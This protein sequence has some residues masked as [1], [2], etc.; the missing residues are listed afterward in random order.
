MLNSCF[1][2][3]FILKKSF[4]KSNSVQVVQCRFKCLHD[5]SGAVSSFKYVFVLY[6]LI[7]MGT[8]DGLTT[9]RKAYRFRYLL[10]DF[11]LSVDTSFINFP[12]VVC[13]HDK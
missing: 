11:L 8:S 10:I 5:F 1:I 3:Q 2:F 4:T 9:L 13:P 6:I 12:A 7:Y